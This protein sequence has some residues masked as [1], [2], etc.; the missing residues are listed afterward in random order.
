MRLTQ[1]KTGSVG[2]PVVTGTRLTL[3]GTHLIGGGEAGQYSIQIGPVRLAPL[4]DSTDE[5]VNVVIS[6]E[7][8]AGVHAIQVIQQRGEG[9]PAGPRVTRRSDALPV[10]VRPAVAVRDVDADTI[11]LTLTPPVRQGQ[12][13]TVTID[14]LDDPAPPPHVLEFQVPVGDTPLTEVE[15]ERT[16]IPVGRWRVQVRVDGVDSLPTLTGE[17]YLGPELVLA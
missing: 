3:A 8:P 12:D 10:V 11:F 9:T 6:K 16:G 5:R 4:P 1:V 13:A 15:L 17:T 7:V 14:R 2:E